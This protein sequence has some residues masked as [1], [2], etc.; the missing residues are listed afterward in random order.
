MP[1]PVEGTVPNIGFAVKLSAT[2]A[3]LTRPP[4][5]LAEHTDE[6]LAEINIDAAERRALRDDGAFG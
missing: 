6:V 1:H 4:P 2:P 3:R 5:L